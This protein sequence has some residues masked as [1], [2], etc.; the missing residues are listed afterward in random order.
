MTICS[1][2]TPICEPRKAER[3]C[4]RARRFTVDYIRRPLLVAHG[5]NDVP[6]KLHESDQI[7]AAMRERGLPVT[8]VVYPDEGHGFLRPES[9]TSFNT[10]AEAFV[11]T[12]LGGRC[13]PFGNDLAGSSL[14]IC[15][16]MTAIAGLRE[17][18]GRR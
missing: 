11:A 2:A 15:E 7:V 1:R 18:L 14:E 4:A 17:C 10:I 3:G 6:C 9:H 12:H 8:Y 13:E 16:G 5:A